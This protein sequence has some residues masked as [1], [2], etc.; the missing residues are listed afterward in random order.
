MS[1]FLLDTNVF[2]EFTK[3][4]GVEIVNPRDAG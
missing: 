4:G 2:S 1:D 3:H